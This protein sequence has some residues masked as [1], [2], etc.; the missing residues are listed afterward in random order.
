MKYSVYL[1]DDSYIS[2]VIL[3]FILL[4]I[5]DSTCIVC[6]RF[7]SEFHIQTNVENAD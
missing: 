2:Y 7:S 4:D 1:M 5:L 3:E 6:A